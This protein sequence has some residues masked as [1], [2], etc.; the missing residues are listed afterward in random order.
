[1]ILW[2]VKIL[3]ENF[4]IFD[5]CLINM[6]VFANLMIKYSS[7]TWF[8]EIILILCF[9]DVNRFIIWTFVYPI[10]NILYIKFLYKYFIYFLKHFYLYLLLILIYLLINYFFVLF[11][12]IWSC[13][14]CCCS[15]GLHAWYARWVFS[16]WRL[17]FFIIQAKLLCL[18]IDYTIEAFVFINWL[19]KRSFCVY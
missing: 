14:W 15:R 12:P 6:H 18:L 13:R 11:Q 10:F 19:Y 2:L 8:Q 9:N 4:I 16:H 1:M 17:C 7:L 5:V 3:N